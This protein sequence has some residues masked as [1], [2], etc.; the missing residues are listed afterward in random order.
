L[1][2]YRSQLRE[3]REDREG[4]GQGARAEAQRLASDNNRLRKRQAEL[5]LAFRKQVHDVL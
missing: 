2:R 5:L 3:L 4:A 1:E